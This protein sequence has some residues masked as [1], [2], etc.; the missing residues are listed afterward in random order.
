[1]TTSEKLRE[2]RIRRK[3][4]KAGYR[5][6]KTPARSWLRGN[7]GAGYMIVDGYPNTV[8]SGCKHHEYPDNLADVESF[9]PEHVWGA[10]A[11]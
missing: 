10:V 6:C 9:A 3:L 8:I 1:M 11:S 4:T 7:Y 2:D 5:L